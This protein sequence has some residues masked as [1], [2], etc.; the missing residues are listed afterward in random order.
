MTID[1]ANLLTPKNKK[2]KFDIKKQLKN[3]IETYGYIFPFTIEEKNNKNFSR[4]LFEILNEIDKMKIIINI[5]RILTSDSIEEIPPL[6]F[7]KFIIDHILE[8]K[9]SHY[10][11]DNGFVIEDKKQLDN[12]KLILKE[13]LSNEINSIISNCHLSFSFFETTEYSIKCNSLLELMYLQFVSNITLSN[14]KFGTC[15][16][17]G[18]LVPI[19]NYNKNKQHIYCR[20]TEEEKKLKYRS[21]CASNA[22][23]QRFRTK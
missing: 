12:I 2:E 19:D 22:A 11:F 20:L 16:F 6:K 13:Y 15:E 4:P 5:H 1:F 10:D 17:C 3:F 23:M 9:S 7:K 21:P 18:K 8:I 14:V